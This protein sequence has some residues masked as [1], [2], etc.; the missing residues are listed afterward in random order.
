MSNTKKIYIHAGAHRTGTSS[1]QQCLAINRPALAGLG[2][3]L[4]YPGRD[5]APEGTLALQL[6]SP[7]H[8]V[9]R[10]G[11]FIE[12]VKR[13]I[14]THSAQA[15]KPLILSEENIPG[16][17]LHFHRAQFYPAAAARLDVLRQGIGGGPE[18]VLLVVRDYKK[19]FESGF[20]KRAEDNPVAPFA[21][22]YEGYRQMDRGWPEI[23]ALIRDVLRPVR[24]SILRYES[25][26]SSVELL[27]HLVPELH[28]AQLQEPE[29]L[30]N[31]S[32]TDAALIALQKRY[33]A[34]EELTRE[35]WQGVILDHA[36]NRKDL[37]FTSY[38]NDLSEE[39]EQRYAHDLGVLAAMDGI[40]FT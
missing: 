9:D 29:R 36:K 3:D 2:Y 1:F 14:R 16:A 25:R 8:G 39:L 28:S 23:V 18:H 35:Q 21:E 12:R 34:G 11:Q 26:G 19:L 24:L 38:P 30:V 27:K 37:G 6:P 10:N 40:E 20:R 7:R 15:D 17:M 4:A 13:A 5:G 31:L 22:R 33:H 32:A